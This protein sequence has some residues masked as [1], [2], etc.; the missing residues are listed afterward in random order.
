MLGGSILYTL[1]C[2]LDLVKDDPTPAQTHIEVT[3]LEHMDVRLPELNIPRTKEA[4]YSLWL[5]DTPKTSPCDYRTAMRVTLP[6][7]AAVRGKTTKRV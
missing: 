5:R 7:Q 1:E 2:C 6:C 3:V 4:A